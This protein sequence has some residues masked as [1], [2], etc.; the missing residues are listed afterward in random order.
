MG[1]HPFGCLRVRFEGEEGTGPGV[2]RGL[3]AAFANALKSGKKVRFF[4]LLMFNWRL[5]PNI[6]QLF[7]N[8]CDFYFLF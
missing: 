4:I 8:A 3:F 2:N 7:G 5:V 6:R 1:N